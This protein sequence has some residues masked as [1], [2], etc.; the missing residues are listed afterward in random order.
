MVCR[1]LSQ[2]CHSNADSNRWHCM[3][4]ADTREFELRHTTAKMRAAMLS[5]YGS[6][7]LCGG[8]RSLSC[9]HWWFP[10]KSCKDF[11]CATAVANI[12]VVCRACHR[13]IHTMPL[14]KSRTL[15]MPHVAK[16]LHTAP[17]DLRTILEGHCSTQHVLDYLLTEL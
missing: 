3:N 9:H 13:A 2:I 12:V 1:Q 6:C 7:V 8:C 15:L 4:E 11:T 16:R 14:Q 10:F 5:I 17:Q